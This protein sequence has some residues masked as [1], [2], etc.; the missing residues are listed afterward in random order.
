MVLCTPVLNPPGV[1]ETP[2]ADVTDTSLSPL[3]SRPPLQELATCASTPAV[4]APRPSGL[5]DP[6]VCPPST[7]LTTAHPDQSSGFSVSPVP[8]LR[9]RSSPTRPLLSTQS[10]SG[11]CR[12]ACRHSGHADAENLCPLHC[13]FCR[14]CHARTSDTGRSACLLP[15]ACGSST[16]VTP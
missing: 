4:S 5:S 8:P 3:F 14:L 1:S 6:D 12:S 2:S 13:W 16:S 15:S 9:T 7:Q 10:H 11:V